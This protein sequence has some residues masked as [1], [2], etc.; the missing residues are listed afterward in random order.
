M[1]R[2]RERKSLAVVSLPLRPVLLP[3]RRVPLPLR[4]L[5]LWQSSA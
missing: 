1:S 5:P 2:K 3:L 4:Q